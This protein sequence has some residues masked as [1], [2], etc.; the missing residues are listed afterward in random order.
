MGVGRLSVI[1][2]GSRVSDEQRQAIVVALRESAAETGH[3]L[4]LAEE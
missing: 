4:A 3:L 1:A 2:L